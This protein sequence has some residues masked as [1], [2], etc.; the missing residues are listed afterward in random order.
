MTTHTASTLARIA[1]LEDEIDQLTSEIESRKQLV[2][3]GEREIRELRTGLG[4][5]WTAE[6]IDWA[7]SFFAWMDAEGKAEADFCRHDIADH[8][9]AYDMLW[10]DVAE[11]GKVDP[12]KGQALADH[13]N[14]RIKE[15]VEER[16]QRAAA[17]HERMEKLR[18]RVRAAQEKRAQD[19]LTARSSSPQPDGDL[20]HA[21]E[22]A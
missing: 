15:R 2:A 18:D 3:S 19:A 13:Y 17:R 5:N 11:I 7:I 1:E 21:S 22:A 12:D 4:V 14:Q 20:R 6:D 16:E 9:V 10:G 8:A